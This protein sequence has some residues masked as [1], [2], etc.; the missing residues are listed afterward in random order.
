MSLP[1]KLFPVETGRLRGGILSAARSLPATYN[2]WRQGVTF[3]QECGASGVAICVDPGAATDKTTNSI[4]DPVEFDP[5]LVYHSKE[6]STWMDQDDILDM[7]RRG[8]ERG[9]S[10]QLA[11]Q[12]QDDIS[13][14][15][16]P[17][18]NDGVD[19]TPGGGPVGIVATL[20]GLLDA[21]ADCELSDLVIHAPHHALPAFLTSNLVEWDDAGSV[22]RIGPHRL[23]VDGYG[24]SG[25]GAVVAAAD[26]SWIYVTGPVEWALGEELELDAIKAPTNEA[27]ALVERLAMLRFDPCCVFGAIAQVC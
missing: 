10:K 1:G 21:A 22:W 3:N 25:I 7:A 9:L 4:A 14:T 11:L 20:C 6:C 26:E 16:N 18:L 12:L 27:I 8:F 23:S 2:E 5:F 17:K 19:L 13:G 24:T 15:G